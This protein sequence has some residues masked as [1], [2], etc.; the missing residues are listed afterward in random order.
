LAIVR[1]FRIGKPRVFV[2]GIDG[3]PFSLIKT[4]G[5]QGLLPNFRAELSQGSQRRMKSA[6]PCVSSVAWACYMTGMNPGRHGIFGFVDRNPETMEL[7]VPTSSH[8]AAETLW[9][10]LSRNGK[11]VVVINVPGTYP[12]RKVNG[13]LVSG[14]LCPDMEKISYPRELASDLKTMGYRIDIDS[15]KA[16]RSTDA[17][18]GDVNE[19]L[20]KRFEAAF[21]LIKRVQW[22][23]FQ[24]H[25]ME[26]DRVNHFLWRKWVEGDSVYGPLFVDFYQKLD[27]YLGALVDRIGD[28]TELVILSDHGFCELQREVYLN[29][30]LEREGFLRMRKESDLV[31]DL[32]PE[33]KAYSLYPGRIYVNLKGREATGVVEEGQDYERTRDHLMEAL[34]GVRDPEKD[35]PIIQRVLKREEVF[36][37]PYLG[38]A[39]DLMAIPQNGYD[40]KGSFAKT[41]L[42]A[43]SEL[44]GMHTYD[45]ALLYVRNRGIQKEDNTFSI[46]DAYSVVLKLMNLE[47]PEGVEAADLI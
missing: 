4:L 2:L 18:L 3:V 6:L 9:E 41:T 47:K 45:D 15:W 35:D 37:G 26:T 19:A 1:Q 27:G 31:K 44:M 20:Q 22:D 24:L 42:T 29:H 39:P 11:R 10:W 14:F 32:H 12:P 36:R 25:V 43:T 23:F 34:L 5:E 46:M 7:F 8:M 33:S 40:L 13:I 21:A 16:R 30:W 28:E 17:F 38:S